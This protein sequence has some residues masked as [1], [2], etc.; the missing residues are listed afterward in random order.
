MSLMTTMTLLMHVAALWSPWAVFGV[1]LIQ[2]S[3]TAFLIIAMYGIWEKWAPPKERAGLI[4]LGISGQ[5]LGNITVFPVSALLCKYGFLGGWPSVFYV[6]GILGVLWILLFYL[7]A[8]DSPSSHRFITEGEKTYITECLAHTGGTRL[9]VKAPWKAILTCLPFWGIVSAH[10]SYTWGLFL[11]LSTLPQYMYEV[12]KFDIKNNGLYAM[13]PYI[14]LLLTTQS[15]GQLNDW[16]IRK[17]FISVVWARK[18]FIVVSHLIPAVVLV[19]LS[20]LDRDQAGLAIM[21]LVTGVGA[22]GFS[23]SGIQV[24]PFD[25]AP[26]FATI[27]MSI[28]NTLATIPGL[29]T[30]VVV[31]AVTKQQTREQWQ[32]VLFLTSG[33]YALGAL[34]FCVLARSDV[35]NWASEAGPQTVIIVDHGEMV[36]RNE[37]NQ[38]S[39]NNK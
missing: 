20:F 33:I 31:A 30:P 17:R 16:L 28:S 3:C 25:I 29:L 34:G 27:M 36:L 9:P 12:L 32:I 10:V 18:M 22:T 11:F 19:G 13:M 4:S 24:T 37:G 14:A 6:F 1:K 7:L 15:S 26:R 2:G 35:Q 21:L 23:V 5:M 8:D 38:S 39:D